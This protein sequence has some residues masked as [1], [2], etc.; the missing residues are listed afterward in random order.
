MSEAIK[1]WWSILRKKQTTLPGFD[2]GQVKEMVKPKNH[3]F[4]IAAKPGS[5][6]LS[7]KELSDLSDAM[8][9][10]LG[11]L[12]KKKEF[13]ITSAEGRSPYGDEPSFM[14]TNVPS[15]YRKAIYELAEK[16]Q[17]EVIAVSRKKQ[18]GATFITPKGERQDK[19]SGM[20]FESKPDFYTE[21]P[22]GQK[23]TFRD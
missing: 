22:S 4:W 8:L 13:T 20:G 1:M 11:K 12:N 5:E 10:D 2:R 21:Y 14:L 15:K 23:L 9:K 17:Q 6:E 18:K 3:N 19:F 16:Y 7:S